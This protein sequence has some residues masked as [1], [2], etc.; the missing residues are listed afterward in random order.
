MMTKSFELPHWFIVNLNY[1]NEL[2]YEAQTIK[3][4]EFLY[5][6]SKQWTM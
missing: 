3:I 6:M 1:H 4:R 5:L 2:K